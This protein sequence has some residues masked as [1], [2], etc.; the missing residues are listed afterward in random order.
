M[1]PSDHKYY[2][3]DCQEPFILEGEVKKCPECGSEEFGIDEPIIK[4]PRKK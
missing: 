3:G 4:T 2:C 1:K